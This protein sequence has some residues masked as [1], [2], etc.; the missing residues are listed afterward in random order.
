[1]IKTLAYL[2]LLMSQLLQHCYADDT[3][4]VFVSILPQKYFVE[5]IAGEYAHVSVMIGPGRGAETYEPS[6]RQMEMLQQAQLYF[7]I[8]LP[9]ETVWIDVLRELNSNLK[10]IACCPILNSNSRNIA[11]PHVWTSPINAKHIA[12]L[13]KQ[14]LSNALPQHRQVFANNYSQLIMDLDR[15]HSYAKSTLAKLHERHIIVYHPAWGHYAADYDLIQIAIESEAKEVSAKSLAELIGFAKSR[16]IRRIF[17]QKQFNRHYA[18]VVASE[19]GADVIE[20][21]PLAEDYLANLYH[22]TNLIANNM[23]DKDDE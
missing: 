8:G 10:I 21:D 22:V 13:V 16:G 3:V 7:Q 14:A 11:D 4:Q 19:I 1:M 18:E 17:V 15:L 6:P 9:F 20:L 2:I 12:L 23:A 5:R